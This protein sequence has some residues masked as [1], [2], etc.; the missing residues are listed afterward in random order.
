MESFVIQPVEDNRYVVR[1][2]FLEGEQAEVVRD[3]FTAVGAEI[4]R[5]AA[6]G[7]S[8]GQELRTKSILAIILVSAAIVAFI[9]FAFR[10][11]SRPVK[12]W[13]YGA[14]AI[15]ALIHDIIIPTGI[16][17]LLG[18]LFGFEVDLLFVMGLLVILG[19]SV[20]DTIVVFDRTREN[21]A[22]LQDGDDATN[23]ING[24]KVSTKST[25]GEV[26]GLSLNQTFARS[27]NT[28]LTTLL[29]LICLYIFG[30]E[31]TNHF[32]LMLIAGI[33]S[34]TYSSIFLASPL[35]V[36]LAGDTPI[37]DDNVAEKSKIKE[38]R[39]ERKA[40]MVDPGLADL[41]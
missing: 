36:Y 8:V 22:R 40:K 16:F 28:S 39:A 38:T 35:L 5:E 18:A 31:S 25:F 21:L 24:E 27:L 4:I 3:S 7:P 33:L 37:L 2:R 32:A 12:S 17:A 1:S 14:V 20:N 10:K 23:V 13:K 6:I 15:V 30:G 29:V 9:A 11:V 19:Y 26:V 34:G 41:V